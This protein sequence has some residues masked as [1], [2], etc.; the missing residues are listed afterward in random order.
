[1]FEMIFFF[2]NYAEAFDEKSTY[3]VT[4]ST[5][6]ASTVGRSVARTRDETKRGKEKKGHEQRFVAVWRRALD[7]VVDQTRWKQSL[8]PRIGSPPFERERFRL[9]PVAF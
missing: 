6:W 2:E 5:T 7:P 9:F 1:M 4:D 8:K 3:R